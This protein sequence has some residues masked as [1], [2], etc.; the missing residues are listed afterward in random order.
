MARRMWWSGTEREIMSAKRSANSRESKAAPMGQVET[1][2]LEKNIIKKASG[3]K[4]GAKRV[5]EQAVGGDDGSTCNRIS[6]NDRTFQRSGALI[7]GQICM[8]GNFRWAVDRPTARRRARHC[9]LRNGEV[10][11]LIL[12][13]RQVPLRQ[14]KIATNY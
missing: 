9:M 1:D 4:K 6:S 7:R 3:C 12:Y 2:V 8:F 14:R 11:R 13:P 10:P 5:N